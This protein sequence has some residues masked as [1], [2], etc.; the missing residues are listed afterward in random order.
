MFVAFIF[1]VFLYSVGKHKNVIYIKRTQCGANKDVNFVEI[2]TVKCRNSVCRNAII[3][4]I[5][6][7]ENQITR[8]AIN[9][10]V[11][12]KI[13]LNQITVLLYNAGVRDLKKIA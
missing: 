1:S 2:G 4:R 13:L 5:F 3:H 8:L 6:D 12:Q 11:S 7:F 9:S 10:Q